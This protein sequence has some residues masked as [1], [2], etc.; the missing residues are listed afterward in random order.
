LEEFPERDVIDK[1]EN[2]ILQIRDIKSCRISTDDSGRISEIHVVAATDRQPKMI[3]RDVDTCL[4][5]ELGLAVDYRKIGVVLIDAVPEDEPEET[6]DDVVDTVQDQDEDDIE[7]QQELDNVIERRFTDRSKI[8]ETTV[9]A[10]HSDDDPVNDDSTQLEFLE[11]DNRA[12]FRGLSLNINESSISVEVKLERNNIVVTGCLEAVRK[13]GPVYEAIAGATVHALTELIEEDFQ[14]CLA[15]IEEVELA[16]K[17]AMIAAV[18]I[19][20]GRS[21]RSYAGSTFVGRD[22]NEATVL[23]VL[24]AINRPFGRWKSIRAIHYRI[25]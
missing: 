23:A 5:A 16:G 18:D 11:D 1:A 25:S 20:D 7:I 14:I 3:A 4:K 19:V 6:D 22:S 13:S 12:R 17:N 24:D 21:V 2:L 8:G 10:H 9:Q 15:G